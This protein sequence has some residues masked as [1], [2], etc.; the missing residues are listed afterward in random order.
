M[1]STLPERRTAMLSW[2]NYQINDKEIFYDI[3]M[4]SYGCQR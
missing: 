4:E 1:G 2:V 3:E